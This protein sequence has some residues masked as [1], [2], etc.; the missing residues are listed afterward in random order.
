MSPLNSINSIQTYLF[1]H[2]YAQ[3]AVSN[4]KQYILHTSRLCFI[5]FIP[6]C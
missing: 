6:G 5:I 1:F 4:I 3:T 2:R